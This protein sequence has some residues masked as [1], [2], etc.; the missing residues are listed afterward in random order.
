MHF[1][2][3]NLLSRIVDENVSVSLKSRAIISTIVLILT[4]RNHVSRV[5]QLRAYFINRYLILSV[6]RTYVTTKSRQYRTFCEC[7]FNT[8][9]VWADDR[10]KTSHLFP[11][12]NINSL[13]FH[14]HIWNHHE[15]CIQISPNR[16]SI[17]SLIRKI[18]VKMSESWKTKQRCL[19]SKTNARVLSVN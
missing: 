2:I 3:C 18:N 5:L 14:D 15:K 16:L 7:T 1:T 11:P 6:T 10:S 19:L 13:E 12:K 8:R 4:R 9:R 17:G